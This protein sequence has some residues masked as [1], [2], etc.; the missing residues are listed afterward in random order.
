MGE[1]KDL[2][3]GPQGGAMALCFL[4]GCGVGWMA[5]HRYVAANMHDELERLRAKVDNLWERATFKDP[6]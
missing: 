2:F 1:V 3:L 5:Y 6:D 4:T